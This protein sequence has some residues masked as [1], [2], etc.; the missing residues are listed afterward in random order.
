M[1]SFFGHLYGAAAV[2]AAAA[3]VVDDLG[4]AKPDQI[5]A[6]FV[7]GVFGGL[8]PDIDSDNSKPA[9]ILFTLLGVA[10]AFL[11]CYLL[12]DDY[13]ILELALI[14]VAVFVLVR[15]GL[16][17][18]FS[19]FTVHRGIWHSWLALGFVALATANAMHYLA[20]VSAWESW[21]AALFVALGYLTHL[22]LDEIASVDLLGNRLKRSFG[23]ALKPFSIASPAA[24]AAMFF[25]A[26]LLAHTAPSVEPVITAT[27]RLPMDGRASL[28]LG[29]PNEHQLTRKQRIQ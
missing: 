7:L 18:V 25:G 16:F 17:E 19:R 26:L 23:T 13:Q 2:S 12:I 24:S 20:E 28:L 5:V 10:A 4:W 21:L 29:S 8:L 27:T 3:L 22:C 1:A 15:F 11:V 9:R 6:F 14:W